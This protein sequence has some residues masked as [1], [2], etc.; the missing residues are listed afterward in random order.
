MNLRDPKNQI[1]IV[2]LILIGAVIYLW[3]TKIFAS[4]NQQIATLAQE[5]GVLAEKLNSV[6]Q[7]AA[8]FDQLEQEY[9]RSLAE[10]QRM[11]LLLP[12][13]KEDEAFLSK[14]HAAAQLTNSVVMEITPMGT[15]NAD[16]YETNSYSVKVKSSYHGL[17]KFFAQIANFPF[18]V[19]LSGLDLKTTKQG[20]GAS[21]LQPDLKVD[22]ERTV[23]ATFKLSTYN[24][25]QGAS[26]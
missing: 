1:F 6:K 22:P 14:I 17:G 16:F 2:V 26:G 7:K 19:N 20:S 12:E 11:E 4:Y 18:I 15:V 3:Y 5:Q 25:K 21:L 9:K 8:T 24:V 23:E 13:K 10:Y